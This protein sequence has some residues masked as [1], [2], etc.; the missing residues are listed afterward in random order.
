M[1]VDVDELIRKITAEVTKQ[2]LAVVQPEPDDWPDWDEFNQV[3][4]INDSPINDSPINDSS[5]PKE[6]VVS[7]LRSRLG[8]EIDAIVED[9]DEDE[10][11]Q[12]TMT[13]GVM[14][15]SADTFD[16]R[17]GG[18]DPRSNPGWFDVQYRR[19]VV[20]PSQAVPR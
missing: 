18:F 14:P 20:L 6:P 17:R 1:S 10:I 2:V 9:D 13:A 16:N 7:A 12:G 19:E 11:S 4:S 3:D 8:G 5:S 15:I